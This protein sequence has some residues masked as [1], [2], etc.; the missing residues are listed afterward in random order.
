MSAPPER[1]RAFIRPA[2]LRTLS[3]VDFDAGPVAL[4]EA[5]TRCVL[6]SDVV[7]DF[8]HLAAPA[9]SPTHLGFFAAILIGASRVEL[10]LGG[11][12]LRMSDEYAEVQRFFALVA[13]DVTPFPKGTGLF[14]TKPL[15]PTDITISNGA[16]G[17]TSHFSVH[18]ATGGR[19]VLL[20]G[21]TL[22]S[23]EVGAVALSGFD[24]VWLRDLHIGPP[25]PPRTTGRFVTLR[26]LHRSLLTGPA[27]AGASAEATKLAAAVARLR[28]LEHA[29][30]PLA[31]DALVRG[32]VLVPAFNVGAV[33][34][35]FADPVRRVRLERL[36]FSDISAA[37]RAVTALCRVGQPDTA[38]LKD[39][40]GNVI[41]IEDLEGDA[42]HRAVAAAQVLVTPG[43]PP[44]AR[45]ELA[46]PRGAGTAR[47]LRHVDGVDTRGHD[48]RGK[49]SCAIRV[50]GTIGLAVLDVRIGAVHSEGERAAAVCLMING[51]REVR[52]E[53]LVVQGG[54]LAT[55]PASSASGPMVDSQRPQGGVYLRG[56]QSMQLNRL[57]LGGRAHCG[58]LLHACNGVRLGRLVLAAPLV[59]THTCRDVQ[60]VELEDES[61]V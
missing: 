16:F 41:C 3:Q 58:M 18:S 27:A 5:D 40:N 36:R 56:C 19:R 44:G 45:A 7:I 12:T 22:A 25:K 57:R 31:S 48:L 30:T 47:L 15:R 28:D 24:D 21:L 51:C 54:A 60:L 33:P 50:D 32:V 6:T 39:V 29:A 1:P 53:D 42:D 34:A 55:Q 23:F 43:L 46:V 37:P 35:H 4:L 26:D 8:R 17:L 49:A 9:R 52:V 20:H 59:C 2:R 38:M 14:T 61:S 10:D 11:H 13:L